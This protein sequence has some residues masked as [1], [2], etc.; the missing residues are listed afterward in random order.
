LEYSN[1]N[2]AE[3]E[4]K[5]D[6][7]KCNQFNPPASTILF[8]KEGEKEPLVEYI[9][10]SQKVIKL[11]E[12]NY[13]VL[14]FNGRKNE[15]SHLTLDNINNYSTAKVNVNNTTGLGPTGLSM[16]ANADSLVCASTEK[17]EI[18]KEMIDK[19]NS[20]NGKCTESSQ[21]AR[22]ELGI[23]PLP[24]SITCN[25]YFEV[26]RLYLVR[27]N[28]VSVILSGI[29]KSAN[30]HDRQNTL[31]A[32]SVLNEFKININESKVNGY[33][34]S[35]C[36][37]LGFPG[38]SIYPYD[39]NSP[40]IIFKQKP[41]PSSF[42]K[43]T[44]GI[45]KVANSVRVDVELVLKDAEKT[46]VKRTY[47]VSSNITKKINLFGEVIYEINLTEN[48]D[49]KIIVP[50]VTPENEQGL[51]PGVNDWGDENIVDIPLNPQK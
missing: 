11:G 51:S 39:K 43:E 32:G 14:A 37:I 42:E 40:S 36:F 9:M 25:I 44:Q 4:I 18:T 33:I 31:D 19:A 16:V 50:N 38:E 29:A 27:P 35:R 22:Y 6:W 47:N 26:D 30:L 15:F 8:Y 24:V 13:S 2:Y 7:Q 21:P 45:G 49:N 28:G 10:G 3:L 34:A 23:Q 41:L 17:L 5:I 20:N 48:P 1:V 12:G 46:I